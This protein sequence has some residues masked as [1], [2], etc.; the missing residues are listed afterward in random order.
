MFEFAAVDL[1][2]TT[3]GK[4]RNFNVFEWAEKNIGNYVNVYG[5]TM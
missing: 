1:F 2:F 5:P 4:A 3:F